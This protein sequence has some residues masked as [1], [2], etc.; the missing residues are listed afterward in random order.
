MLTL[1][2]SLAHQICLAMNLVL[3]GCTVRGDPLS[4]FCLEILIGYMFGWILLPMGICACY[5]IA[6]VELSLPS[7]RN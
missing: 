6:V 7:N 4:V 3:S 1:S 2:V 5:N